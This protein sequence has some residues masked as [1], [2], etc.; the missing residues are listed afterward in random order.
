MT[1]LL[2][3]IATHLLLIS[4]SIAFMKGLSKSRKAFTVET[5][6]VTV[7]WNKADIFINDTDP[8]SKALLA[9]QFQADSNEMQKKL[10]LQET[11]KKLD[12][13]DEIF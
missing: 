12:A 5:T 6:D 11:K 1:N 13:K 10:D 3:I 9:L 8:R 7:F 4:F 2:F